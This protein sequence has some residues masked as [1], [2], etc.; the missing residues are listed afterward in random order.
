MS[1]F[2]QTK[3]GLIRKD[4][5]RVINRNSY[6]G[7]GR[8]RKDDYTLTARAFEERQ[9]QRKRVASIVKTKRVEQKKP[10]SNWLVKAVKAI[11]FSLFLVYVF[12]TVTVKVPQEVKSPTVERSHYADYIK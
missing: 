1:D 11:W 7:R 4:L 6:K 9:K 5:L 10:S 3:D 8:P 2:K 12:Q